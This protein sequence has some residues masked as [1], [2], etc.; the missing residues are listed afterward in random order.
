MVAAVGNR[1]EGLERSAFGPVRLDGL[2]AGAWRWASAAVEFP[3]A[4]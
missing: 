3:G 4:R 1:V 2:P